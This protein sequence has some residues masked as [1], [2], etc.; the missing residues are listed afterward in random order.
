MEKVTPNEEMFIRKGICPDCALKLYRGPMGGLA[1][2]VKCV[3]DHKFWVAGSFTPER[4]SPK[5]K[6]LAISE[7]EG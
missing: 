6:L 7:K 4:I 1:M 5:P 2:N 3:N